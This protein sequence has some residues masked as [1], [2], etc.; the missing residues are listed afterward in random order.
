MFPWKIDNRTSAVGRSFVISQQMHQKL[1][2]VCA[3]ENEANKN[4]QHDNCVHV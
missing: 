3:I 1:K 2:T 4:P